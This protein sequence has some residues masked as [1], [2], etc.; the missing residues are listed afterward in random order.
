MS[1][2]S[3]MTETC[4][5]PQQIY[6]RASSVRDYEGFCPVVLREGYFN[7]SGTFVDCYEFQPVDIIPNPGFLVILLG[8][9][10]RDST[11]EFAAKAVH[12]S[13]QSL[14]VD[15][16]GIPVDLEQIRT[17]AELKASINKFRNLYSHIV[18][19]GHGSTQGIGFLDRDHPVAGSDLA[20]VFKCFEGCEPLQII[21]L[22]CHSGADSIAGG[23]SKA[24]NV[25]EVI[26]PHAAF[27]LQWAVHFV[28]GYL[29]DFFLN[30]ANVDD[31]VKNSARSASR[32]PMC[33]W[34][35]GNLS[36]KC[37]DTVESAP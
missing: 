35:N 30:G 14:F 25:A 15:C 2:K 27:H 32:T 36:C 33:V 3:Q 5:E 31:A 10:E 17:F 19:V 11:L 20:D 8:S 9:V 12:S 7:D 1:L 26:A 29:L 24:T 34:R 16:G 28:T 23:L 6:V 4:S 13:I 22:C 21:S 18:I 37:A